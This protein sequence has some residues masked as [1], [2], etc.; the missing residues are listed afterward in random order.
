M[1]HPLLLEI[2]TRCWLRGRPLDAVPDA[3]IAEW[4]ARGFTH[5]WLMGVW[6]AGPKTGEMARA[7]PSLQALSQEAFG[8]RGADMIDSSPFA[9]ADFTAASWLGGPAALRA[10]RAKLHPHGLGLFLDFIPNH[11]GLDHRWLRE[12]PILFVQSATQKPETFLNG[13]AWVALGKDPWFPAWCDTAQLDYRRAETRAAMTETLLAIASQCDGVRCD[14]AMLLLNDVFDK[15][16]REFPSNVP[17][18]PEEFWS[19]AI[20]AVKQ[21]W[22]GFIFLAEAY[23]DL[24]PRLAE[25]GFDY[26]YDK[27]FLDHLARRDA[28]ALQRHL[29]EVA[30]EFRPA[31]FLE[32]HDEARISAVLAMPEQKAAAVLLLSQ[33]GLRMIFDGQCE[34]KHRRTPVQFTRYWPEPGDPEITPF[35]ESLLAALAKGAIGRGE[36]EMC[37]TG[38]PQ[39]FA[40]KW[41]AERITLALVNFGAERAEFQVAGEGSA[42]ASPCHGDSSRARLQP[43][44]PTVTH[45]LSA[46]DSTW[47]W[48]NGALHIGLAGYGFALLELQP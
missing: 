7:Q 4:K 23:W 16:W 45:I 13:A 34:G 15:T 38:R 14:M 24:E 37:E 41:K 3:E 48:Q 9:V 47:A 31:R 42:G 12:R 25:L 8:A 39:C 44:L 35:Y 18:P 33:P 43:S 2:N 28:P 21:R 27:K 26:A 10:F 40:M 19:G 30:G 46:P 29:R 36:W 20:S 32:N 6:A 11:L 1:A 5:I 22:P 17:A